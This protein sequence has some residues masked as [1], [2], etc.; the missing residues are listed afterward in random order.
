MAISKVTTTIV[1]QKKFS[2]KLCPFE[3]TRISHK[4][5]I[6]RNNKFRIEKSWK[7]DWRRNE[8][9]RHVSMKCVKGSS[10]SS[11]ENLGI[12]LDR[13]NVAT[14]FLFY[15]S[16]RWDVRQIVDAGLDLFSKES[17]S[18]TVLHFWLSTDAPFSVRSFP[19]WLDPASDPA[20]VYR[21]VNVVLTASSYPLKCQKNFLID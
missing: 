3:M 10:Q 11:L 9:S 21:V 5:G 16:T 13:R 14:F 7:K 12:A 2:V 6:N 15:L 17:N 20:N 4:R 19:V 1:I 18:M 8:S